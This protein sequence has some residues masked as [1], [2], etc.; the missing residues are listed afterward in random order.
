MISSFFFNKDLKNLDSK[1]YS[2]DYLKFLIADE[3][4]RS[5][6]KMLSNY[7]LKAKICTNY[8]VND[9]VFTKLNSFLIRNFQYKFTKS[10]TILI[11]LAEGM[12]KI[13]ELAYKYEPDFQILIWDSYNTLLKK[14]SN[15]ISN[16]RFNFLDALLIRIAI[17]KLSF[18]K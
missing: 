10:D 13:I 15:I 4:F 9:I 18:S 17:H 1:K 12:L 16:Y 8:G 7:E 6:N 3:I 5:Q 2:D 14:F 11:L